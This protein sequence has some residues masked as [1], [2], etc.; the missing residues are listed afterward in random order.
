MITIT[1]INDSELTINCDLIE[2]IESTPDTTITMTTG[3]KII[4]KESIADIIDR[5]VAFKAAPKNIIK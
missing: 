2:T 5:I 3:R 1:R 4:A